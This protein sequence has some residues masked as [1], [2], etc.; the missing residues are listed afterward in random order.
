MP[1]HTL[2]MTTGDQNTIDDEDPSQKSISKKNDIQEPV[3]FD[4]Q[5]SDGD[6]DD[7]E[8]LDDHV[9]LSKRSRASVKNKIEE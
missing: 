8:V 6:K 2:E 7:D 5:G 1:M 4:D 9:N 3:K